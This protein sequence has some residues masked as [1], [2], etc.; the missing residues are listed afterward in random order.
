MGKML[1]KEKKIKLLGWAKKQKMGLD[2]GDV[3]SRG[4]TRPIYGCTEK[5]LALAF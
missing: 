2:P 4:N 5:L 1:K 3:K